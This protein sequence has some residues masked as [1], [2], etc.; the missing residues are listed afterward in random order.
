MS[1]DVTG[2]HWLLQNERA[3]Q[4]LAAHPERT[5]GSISA[6]FA[7]KREE[8]QAWLDKYNGGKTDLTSARIHAVKTELGLLSV[9]RAPA[10][11]AEKSVRKA[12]PVATVEKPRTWAGMR[13]E[14]REA[15]A[16][17]PAVTTQDDGLSPWAKRV[18]GPQ[19]A[20]VKKYR[21]QLDRLAAGGSVDDNGPAWIF[22]LNAWLGSRFPAAT[23]V[24]RFLTW[25]DGGRSAPIPQPAA[26]AVQPAASKSAPEREKSPDVAP[27]MSVLASP[28]PRID[29]IEPEDDCA[30]ETGSLPS[31]WLELNGDRFAGTDDAWYNG[32]AHNPILLFRRRTTERLHEIGIK[33]GLP[34]GLMWNPAKRLL[35]LTRKADGKV[36]L[37][38]ERALLCVK[39]KDLARLLGTKKLYF[40]ILDHGSADIPSLDMVF[41]VK[42]GTS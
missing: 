30:P 11:G 33:K 20:T 35:G 13:R 16:E 29:E 14:Q 39:R 40:Q 37:Q 41:E 34:I 27:T 23:R 1:V 15:R 10:A 8:L 5:V 19:G 18:R 42:G 12:E 2:K 22:F 26:K 25:Y 32:K 24:R 17:K 21:S 9:E 7:V 4:A 31:G 28:A 6:V 36:R 38:A 3:L